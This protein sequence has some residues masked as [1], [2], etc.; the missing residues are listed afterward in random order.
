[1]RSLSFDFTIL[2]MTGH[3]KILTRHNFKSGFFLYNTL[4]QCQEN[5]P[6]FTYLAVALP[7]KLT[8]MIY[9]GIYFRYCVTLQRDLRKGN[10]VYKKPDKN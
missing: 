5:L 1:M 10:I 8:V 3:I 9:S 2:N 4:N 7:T 6:V